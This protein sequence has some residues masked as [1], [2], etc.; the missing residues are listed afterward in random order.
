MGERHLPEWAHIKDEE[1][2]WLDDDHAI[3][4]SRWPGESEPHGGI[5]WHRKGDATWCGGSW[6]LRQPRY[7][8]K[9]FKEP[10][11]IWT[12]ES[13]EPLTLSP[14]FLCHCKHHGWIRAGVWV[15]A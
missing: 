4:W 9:T 14:S 12:M 1:I 6:Y 3:T 7:N 13:K 11:P 10:V 5:L 15:S 8:G 2:I